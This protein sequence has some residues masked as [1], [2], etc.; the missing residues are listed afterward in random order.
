MEDGTVTAEEGAGTAPN[1]GAAS[2]IGSIPAYS[3]DFSSFMFEKLPLIVVLLTVLNLVMLCIWC[4][5]ARKPAVYK[6]V[7]MI[8][9]AETDEEE[10]KC[11]EI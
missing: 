9:D 4:R 8:S 1:C 11:L 7:A 10:A 6:K 5:K 2:E 3:T